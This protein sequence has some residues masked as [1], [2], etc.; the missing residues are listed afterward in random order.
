MKCHSSNTVDRDAV[1]AAIRAAVE[2]AGGKRV[3]LHEFLAGSEMCQGD[4]FRHFARWEE[5]LRAA[6]AEFEP[7]N[8]RIDPARLLADWGAV[9]REL[10]RTP[11]RAEYKVRGKFGA[12]TV[13]RRFGGWTKVREAFREFAG[14]KEEWSDVGKMLAVKRMKDEGG[15][16]KRE[17]DDQSGNQE[18]RNGH[19]RRWMTRGRCGANEANGTNRTNGANGVRKR[20][21]ML[22]RPTYGEPLDFEAMRHEP[23]NECGVIFLF[24]MMAGRLGFL[25]EALRPNFPDCE[26]KR[27]LGPRE[28]QRVRIEFEYE[29]RNFR[30]HAHDPEG[31][32]LIVCWH[33]NWTDC[34]LEVISLKDELARFAGMRKGGCYEVEESLASPLKRRTGRINSRSSSV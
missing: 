21:R 7:R 9:A 3:S 11:S 12:G 23:V 34:P 6:G 32:D 30:D 24:A 26:A 28:W 25:V 22:D 10:Q 18:I 13:E 27:R 5:A 15:G 2:A 8:A 31:C 20:R 1:L 17:G 14:E 29:S 16:M 4:V 33:H 19:S